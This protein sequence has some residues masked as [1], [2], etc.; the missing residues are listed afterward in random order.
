MR[1][2]LAARWAPAGPHIH[3]DHLAAFIG[4][5]MRPT[6]EGGECEIARGMTDAVR[7]IAKN[8]MPAG[9]HREDRKHHQH[10]K[11][12]KRTHLFSPW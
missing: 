2:A 10:H 6:S 12:L 3:N 1:E 9:N 4:E 5:P 11:R 8:K 7:H